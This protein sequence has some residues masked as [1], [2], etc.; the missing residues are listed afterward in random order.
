MKFCKGTEKYPI[1]KE[2]KN[3][4]EFVDMTRKIIQKRKNMC[5]LQKFQEKGRRQ[6]KFKTANYQSLKPYHD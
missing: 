1:R 4:V 3:G 2:G 5:D 6:A